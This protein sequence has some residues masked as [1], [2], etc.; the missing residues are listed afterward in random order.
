[1]SIAIAAQ[2]MESR[3]IQFNHIESDIRLSV[4]V[5]ST[6]RLYDAASGRVHSIYIKFLQICAICLRFQIYMSRL[7]VLI[8]G[9]WTKEVAL[10]RRMPHISEQYRYVSSQRDKL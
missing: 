8:R 9:D 4:G 6:Y 5:V 2:Q 10:L 1:M 3:N 7:V